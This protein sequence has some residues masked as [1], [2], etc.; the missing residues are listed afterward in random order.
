RNPDHLPQ[1]GRESRHNSP[2]QLEIEFRRN[3]PPLGTMSRN[4]QASSCHWRTP[5][6]AV[7]TKRME[8]RCNS[9]PH[10]TRERNLRT[11]SCRWHT[12][13][14][15][16]SPQGGRENRGDS[17]PQRERTFPCNEPWL[18]TRKRND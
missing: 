5:S 4:Y 13:H 14:P 15:N 17:P 2:Q 6:P 7:P 18:P 8:S 3:S 12:P 16:P 11:S 10:A 1:A 9:P